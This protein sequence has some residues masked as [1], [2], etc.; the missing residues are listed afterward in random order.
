MKLFY[1][2]KEVLGNSK[3]PIDKVNFVPLNGVSKIKCNQI[4][5]H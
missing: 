5:M 2:L 3:F 1:I 4:L